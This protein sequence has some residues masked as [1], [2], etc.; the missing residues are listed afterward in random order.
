MCRESSLDDREAE[1]VVWDIEIIE[2]FRWY[3]EIC[4]MCQTFRV[5]LPRWALS[6][7]MTFSV[8]YKRQQKKTRKRKKQFFSHVYF[9]NYLS[10]I[11]WERERERERERQTD[12]RSLLSLC[13]SFVTDCKVSKSNNLSCHLA[14][15]KLWMS[16]SISIFERRNEKKNEKAEN[17]ERMLFLRVSPQ[18]ENYCFRLWKYTK[19]LFLYP[20]LSPSFGAPV[21]IVKTYPVKIFK[22]TPIDLQFDILLLRSPLILTLSPLAQHNNPIRQRMSKLYCFKHSNVTQSFSFSLTFSWLFVWFWERKK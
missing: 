13:V 5:L 11:G 2:Y 14:S 15:L 1:I 9:F 18:Q 12:G 3:Q 20:S 17:V 8:C 4:R 21:V 7:G 16:W 6:A 22:F 19:Q 10:F